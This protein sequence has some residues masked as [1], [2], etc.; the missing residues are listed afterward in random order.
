MI[1]RLRSLVLLFTLLLVAGCGAAPLVEIQTAIATVGTMQVSGQKAAEAAYLAEQEACAP[2][3]EGDACVAKVRVDW[4][5]IK[6]A[7]AALYVAY[8]VALATYQAAQASY[9]VTKTFDVASVTNAL[10]KLLAAADAWRS[11]ITTHGGA[12]TS[13]APSPALPATR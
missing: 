13:P 5:P 3:P 12:R 6:E 7:S 9:L 1:D 4:K 11:A 2:P 10:A 8:N